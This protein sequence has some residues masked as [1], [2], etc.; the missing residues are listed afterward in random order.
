[1]EVMKRVAPDQD[2]H[3]NTLCRDWP[4]ILPPA[5]PIEDFYAPLGH[6]QEP[7]LY[8]VGFSAEFSAFLCHGTVGVSAN[9]FS[10]CFAS[11]ARSIYG[12]GFG[13]IHRFWKYHF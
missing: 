8:Q 11:T 2:T 3:C 6:S 10:R 13:S 5:V 9:S 4:D 7:R 12:N 1:M